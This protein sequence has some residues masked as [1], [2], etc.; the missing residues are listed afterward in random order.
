MFDIKFV[1]YFRITICYIEAAKK[2]KKQYEKTKDELRCNNLKLEY[3]MEELNIKKSEL[4]S[5]IV[6][7]K[8]ST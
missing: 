2:E 5:Q 7:V 8:S 6:A 3:A 4:E 1:V